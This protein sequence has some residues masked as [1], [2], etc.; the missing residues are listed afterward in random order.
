MRCKLRDIW[1][2]LQKAET[3]LVQTAVQ[4]RPR[5]EP[6]VSVGPDLDPALRP[7]FARSAHCF[8][9]QRIRAVDY[10]SRFPFSSID[11]IEGQLRSL[12]RADVLTGP[13]GDAYALTDEAERHLRAHMGRIGSFIDRLDLAEIEETAI[14][15]LLAYDHRIVD[16][17][18]KSTSQARSPIFEHRLRGLHPDYERPMRW[19]HW[20]LAW[21]MIAAYEDAQEQVRAT[22][23]IDPLLWFARHEMWFSVRRPHRA[24]MR[25]C[26]DLR[27]TAE[28]Y[29]PLSN[30]AAACRETIEKL[31]GLG[32]V[33]GEGEDCRLTPLGLDLADR[34]EA[35][36]LDIFLSR[37]PNLGEP[38][39]QELKGITDAINVRCEQ[40]QAVASADPEG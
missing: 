8:D 29:A 4:L 33:E 22:R 2:S 34:D 13:H 35:V 23:Q 19:H 30:A 21:T 1:V 6:V 15:R 9:T 18:R 20:Q 3:M 24:R 36:T 17:L 7:L 28:R 38:E 27:A 16:A 32:W 25:S 12:V 26:T 39:C 31:R 37:W 5:G 40:L 10:L 14:E 11:A